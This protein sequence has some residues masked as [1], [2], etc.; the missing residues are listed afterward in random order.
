MPATL[1]QARGHVA[2][3]NRRS[4]RKVPAHLL[5]ESKFPPLYI[6]N[7]SD[8]AFTVGLGSLGTYTLPVCKPGQEYSD[9]LKI[10]GMTINYYDAGD[11]TGKQNYE[12][13]PAHD[14]EDQNRSV[15]NAILGIPLTPD[16]PEVFTN[17]KTWFGLFYSDK[18]EPT[19][20]QL[21]EARRKLDAIMTAFLQAGD[22]LALEGAKGLEQ[23]GP[24]HRK[25][26]AFKKQKR[27]W[28]MVP[29]SKIDCPG[30]GGAITPSAVKCVACGAVLNWKKAY[31]LGMVASP[32]PP[33]AKK[34]V[35]PGA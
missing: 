31:E 20:E 25:A 9:P 11:G 18:P 14:P 32:N 16:K 24:M 7:I 3:L 34:D 33:S 6:F 2:S 17:N 19:K 26:A 21:A 4:L 29:E 1:E 27:D 30:C 23:V 5:D 35:Q 8:N 22:K 13:Y 10:P 15:I 12:S 28:S